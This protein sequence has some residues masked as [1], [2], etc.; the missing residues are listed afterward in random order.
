MAVEIKSLLWDQ[1]GAAIDMIGNAITAC[2]DALWNDTSRDPQYWY[3]TYHTLFWLDFYLSDTAYGF[4]PPPPFTL[5]EFDPS[6]LLPDRIY[7]KSE[8]LAY[9]AHGRKKCENSM[10][11]LNDS[12]SDQVRSFGRVQGTYLELLL[13]NMR[14]VQHHAAQLNMLLRQSGLDAPRWVSRAL[15]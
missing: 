8:L 14:H 4:A 6:G 9:L 11:N 12:R 7:S 1:F 15:N 5:S 13:Y 2:P 3:L 10:A